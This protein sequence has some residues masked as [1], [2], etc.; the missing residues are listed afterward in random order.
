ML[1][2]KRNIDYN[3]VTTKKKRKLKNKRNEKQVAGQKSNRR[4]VQWEDKPE[5][6]SL[7]Q[8]Q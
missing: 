5:I 7:K 8:I 6:K 3:I 2:K 1:D 4:S